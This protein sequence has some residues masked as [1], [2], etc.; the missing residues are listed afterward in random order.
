ME[1]RSVC[2]RIG[3]KVDLRKRRP[4]REYKSKGETDG[5]GG[6]GGGVG[7]GGG[8]GGGK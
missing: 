1:I 2:R 5:G 7:G 6:G 3:K 4:G 8:G